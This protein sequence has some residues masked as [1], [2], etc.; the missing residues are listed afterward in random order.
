MKNKKNIF[1]NY[2]SACP[3]CGAELDASDKFCKYCGSDLTEE[4]KEYRKTEQDVLEAKE[5][6]EQAKADFDRMCEEHKKLAE[7]ARKDVNKRI[8]RLVLIVIC[9]FG[10][11]FLFLL[12]SSL[13]MVAFETAQENKIE[14][15]KQELLAQKVDVIQIPQIQE[16][17]LENMEKIKNINTG[18]VVANDKYIKIPIFVEDRDSVV[19]YNMDI[20]LK[21]SDT[22]EDFEISSTS[23]GYVR[24]N[25]EDVYID[26]EVDDSSYYTNAIDMIYFNHDDKIVRRNDVDI[27]GYRFECYEVDKGYSVDYYLVSNIKDNILF[28][29]E[30]SFY[31]YDDEDQQ[32]LDETFINWIQKI[33]IVEN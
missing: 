12:G 1:S 17:E 9:I 13:L 22:E 29:Y 23:P 18:E 32:N 24:L 25:K 8:K 19:S 7:E 21:N 10:V 4:N 26:I 30:I 11:G 15:I 3:M 20:Y 31:Y 16:E 6:V 33:E 28:K 5:D 14:N 27:D 2:V